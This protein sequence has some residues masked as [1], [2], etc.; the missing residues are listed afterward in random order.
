[1]KINKKLSKK[2][3]RLLI[4]RTMMILLVVALIGIFTVKLLPFVQKLATEES[5]LEL[6]NDIEGMGVQGVLVTLGL[7]ILQIIVAVIPGQPMEII[8]GMLYGTLGGMLLC[9]I[10]ILIGNS[11][12]FFLVRKIGLSFIELFFSNEKIEQIKKK[13]IFKNAAKLEMFMLVMFAIPL[14]PKD[15]FVYIAGISPVRPKR[16]LVLSTLARIPGLWLTVYAGN[17][18]SKGSFL[19]AG[20][21]V[22]IFIMIG[23]VGYRISNHA[24]KKIEEAEL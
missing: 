16:F 22:L 13:K 15:I 5:R 20:I 3:K 17:Q 18:L 19:V 6:K 2:E 4:I 14:L 11:V 7:Q 1:M 12:V 9:L 23:I 21:L 24:E 10:G 8:S